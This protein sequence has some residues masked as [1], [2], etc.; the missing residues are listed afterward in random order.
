MPVSVIT[1]FLGAGKTTLFNLITGVYTPTE[2]EI[3]L[4]GK[5]IDDLPAEE[6][7]RIRGNRISMIFQE[8]MTSLNPV[9]TVGRQI[10]EAL[11]L[12]HRRERA[13]RVLRP[14]GARGPLAA[15]CLSVLAGLALDD[16]ATTGLPGL[17]ALAA[18]RAVHRQSVPTQ[19]G[20]ITCPA[21]G[22]VDRRVQVGDA[23]GILHCFAWPFVRGFAVNVSALHSA[24]PHQHTA[25]FG[26]VPVHAVVL[27]LVD[28]LR[29]LNLILDDVVG[30]PL[31]HHVAA[32]L[33]GEH[34]EGPVEHAALL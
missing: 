12:H 1:G 23:H 26:E 15:G 13:V 16:D 34:D 28:H 14:G 3:R 6:M 21:H 11:E 2:G 20:V 25:G 5:R 29:H 9:L 8:P 32:E 27:H 24:A 31:H 4:A 19:F 10:G 22:R 7:R 30:L 33:A 17:A 18:T